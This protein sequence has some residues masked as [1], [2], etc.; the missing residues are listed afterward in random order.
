MT[1]NLFNMHTQYNLI[2]SVGILSRYDNAH[3][4]LVL[5]PEFKLT[6]RMLKSLSKIYDRV[7]VIREDFVPQKS[8]MEEIKQTRFYLNLKSVKN[9]KN[10]KFD[11]IFM[12]QE[13]PFDLILCRRYRKN[14]KS[15]K[16]YHIEEDAYYSIQEKYNEPDFS[17]K[18]TTLTKMKRT[19]FALLLGYPYSYKEVI[20]CYGMSSEY[21]GANLL[22]PHVAR[23]ELQ[24]KELLE[25][26]RAELIYGI[27]TLYR[28]QRFGLPL[29]E[30][31]TVFFFDLISR[32]K[33]P[34]IIKII[35]KKIVEDSKMAGRAVLLKYHPRET[36]KFDDIV[37][38]VEVPS[39]IPAEKI[40]LD[41]LNKDVM[42]FGN[43]TTCCIVAAKLGFNVCSVCKIESPN[44]KKMHEIM[45][46]IGVF[47]PD[48]IMI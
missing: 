16:C 15:V 46:T 39:D 13:R 40:L 48:E 34:E 27:E 18:L 11:N 3:N 7:I 31:Y 21:D 24:G 30:K 22:F 45:N 35:V 25:V 37:G 43:A 32:Y 5:F 29:S 17:F 8:A 4:T 26:T 33:Q 6:S 14:N 42:V 10:E 23:R 41:L 19:L 36:E 12:S 9:I 38:G 2:L 28:E 20:Y 47:C 44:N 1:K